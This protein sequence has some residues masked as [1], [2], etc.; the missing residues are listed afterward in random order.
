MVSDAGWMGWD[1]MDGFDGLRLVGVLVGGK[2][3][4]RVEG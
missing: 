1:G 3:L 2:F 4:V